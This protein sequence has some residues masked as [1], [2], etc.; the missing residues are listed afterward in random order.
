MQQFLQLLMSQWPSRCCRTEISELLRVD[1]GAFGDE[2]LVETLAVDHDVEVDDRQW[3][4][5][6]T[7]RPCKSRSLPGKFT[8]T[9]GSTCPLRS[10]W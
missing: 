7:E 1:L 3:P 6:S 9:A 10:V 8:V 4:T 5:A 2:Q